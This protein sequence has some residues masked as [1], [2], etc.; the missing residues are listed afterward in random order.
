M[1]SVFYF[2]FFKFLNFQNLVD[3]PLNMACVTTAR[4]CNNNCYHS[5][6]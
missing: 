5:A 2:V 6:K 4:D 3:F 1:Y